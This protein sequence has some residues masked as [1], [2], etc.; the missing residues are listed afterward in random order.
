MAS[1]LCVCLRW[2]VAVLAV[3]AVVGGGVYPVRDVTEVVCFSVSTCGYAS[4]CIGRGVR[5]I[6]SPCPWVLA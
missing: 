3:L 5:G 1:L 4:T 6:P 2:C